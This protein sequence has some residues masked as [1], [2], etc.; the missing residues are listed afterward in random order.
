MNRFKACSLFVA[1]LLV[2]AT[3]G[4]SAQSNNGG[5]SG[6]DSGDDRRVIVAVVGIIVVAGIAWLVSSSSSSTTP[7]ADLDESPALSLDVEPW[8]SDASSGVLFRW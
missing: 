8:V 4:V 6:G 2:F 3:V 7:T 5:D 1:L